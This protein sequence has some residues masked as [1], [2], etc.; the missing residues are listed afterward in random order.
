MAVNRAIEREIRALARRQN[1]VVTWWQLLEAGLTPAA[2]KSRA[3]RGYLHRLHRAVYAVGDPALLPLAAQS[4]ALLSVG[5]QAVLSHRSAA[6]IWCLAESVPGPIDVSVASGNPR[7]RG[8][9]RIHRVNALNQIDIALKSH[10]RLTAPARTVVDFAGEARLAE[11][12]RALSEARALRLVNDTQ[13]DR[14]LNRAPAN[15]PGA[16]KLKGLLRHPAGQ[17]MTRSKLERDFLRLIEAAGLPTPKVNSRLHGFEP[18]FFWPHHQL[19]VEVDG[20]GFHGSRPAFEKD[21]RRDQAFAAAGIRVLRATELQIDR[22]P[23][24][25]AVRIAQA[26]GHA[27]ATRP[28]PA[29]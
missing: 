25:L 14:A 12:E 10:L 4:A 26:L 19:V 23:I 16:A 2:I 17:T 13:L 28:S 7:P 3:D 11:L 27:L 6:A 5:G 29:T 20:Y 21:R 22:E 8:H 15:H 1:G 24:G 9:V 18:D